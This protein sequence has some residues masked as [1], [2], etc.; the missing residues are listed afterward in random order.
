MIKILKQSSTKPFQP[1]RILS[2]FE[3]G[4]MKAFEEKFPGVETK[5]CNFD[6]AQCWRKIQQLATTYQ[7]HKEIRNGSSF[8]KV[9]LLYR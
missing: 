1:K 2:D 3:D 5:G 8:L 7:N 6:M 4:A 9:F